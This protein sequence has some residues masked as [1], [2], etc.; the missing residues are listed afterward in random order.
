MPTADD[1]TRCTVQVGSYKRS[2]E[3]NAKRHGR[4]V[5]NKFFPLFAK[6]HNNCSI[7]PCEPVNRFTG[8]PVCACKSA[9]SLFGRSWWILAS[10]RTDP[11]YFSA[12]SNSW[13]R[14]DHKPKRA[15]IFNAPSRSGQYRMGKAR[16]AEESGNEECRSL[17]AQGRT[18]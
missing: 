11:R 6:S 3:S 14:L 8:C 15:K 17:S 5:A 9:A 7:G 18:P 2:S 4:D 16:P 10:A 1:A 12:R 13:P